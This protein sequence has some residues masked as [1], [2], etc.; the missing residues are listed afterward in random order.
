MNDNIIDLGTVTIPTNWD[1]VTLLQFQDLQRI[2]K[3]E[4]FDIRKI[5]TI[6]IGKTEDELN[7]MPV[8]FLDIMLDKLKFLYEKPLQQEP[9]N[10]M[11][12][13][14][15]IYKINYQNK[16]KVGEYVA[17]EMVL[18]DDK[19]NYAGLL[20]VL[21]RK[22]NEIYDSKY[23]NEIL[24]D[25]IKLFQNQPITKVLPIIDFFLRLSMTLQ[26]P[27]ALSTEAEELINRSVQTIKTL[28]T[29]GH[30]SKHSMRQHM[31]TLMKLKESIKNI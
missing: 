28:Q 17:A 11:E 14:G 8:E 1:E 10:E 31:K 2:Y 4:D 6:F 5:L 3:D 19:Y 20:A 7:G 30:L 25:R 23:E 9:S 16:L 29:N 21:C 27:I 15:E 22:E 12:I 18:K 26:L 24:E 13:D